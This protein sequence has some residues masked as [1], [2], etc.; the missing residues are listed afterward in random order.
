MDPTTYG[1]DVPQ[2]EIDNRE[3][4]VDCLT[5]ALRVD[6]RRPWPDVTKQIA[7]RLILLH[8]EYEAGRLTEFPR[9]G[10]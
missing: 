10:R 6:E 8:R 5:E 1:Y 3:W 7:G 4:A 2:A 9:I